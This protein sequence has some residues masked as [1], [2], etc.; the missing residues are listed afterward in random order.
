MLKENIEILCPTKKVVCLDCL[1]IWKAFGHSD[2]AQVFTLELR[3]RETQY[4]DHNYK[5]S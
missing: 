1:N 2:M 4:A 5:S 3:S